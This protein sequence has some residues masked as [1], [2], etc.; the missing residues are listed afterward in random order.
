ME[1]KAH[2]LPSESKFSCLTASKLGRWIFPV[3]RCELNLWLILGLEPASL[4]NGTRPCV[5]LPVRSLDSN[6]NKTIGSPGSLPCQLTLHILRLCQ[7][8]SVQSLSRVRL[9]ASPWTTAHQASLSITNSGGLPKLMSIKSEIPSNHLIL[10]RPLLL[11]SS[12][13][14]NIRVF[15]NESV[16]CISGQSIGVSASTSVLPMNTQDWS[17]SGWTGWISLQSKG[18]STVFSNTLLIL[19]SKF[20]KYLFLL[21]IWGLVIGGAFW[22]DST[23][24][25]NIFPILGLGPLYSACIKKEYIQVLPYD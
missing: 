2:L 7:F 13:F 10:Y 11:L 8:S 3:F 21:V 17:P 16:L 4:P 20:S 5:L 15:S 24:C 1:E 9:F 18:L 25:E 22:S 14:P 19:V 12:I 23:R 6:W